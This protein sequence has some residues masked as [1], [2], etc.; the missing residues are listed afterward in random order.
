MHCSSGNKKIGGE[1]ISFYIRRN[2]LNE[3][4]K[5]KLFMNPDSLP[6]EMDEKDLRRKRYKNPFR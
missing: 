5:R 3:E 2:E 6:M 4:L 1:E